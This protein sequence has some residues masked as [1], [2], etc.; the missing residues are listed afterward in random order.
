MAALREETIRKL[1]RDREIL[2]RRFSA[3]RGMDL[4]HL[5]PKNRRRVLQALRLRVEIDENGDAGISGMFDAD[6]TELLPMAQAPADEPYTVQFKHEIPPP[7]KG[8]VTL[9]NTPTAG[10]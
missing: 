8:V 2:L 7:Y 4:R 3:M 5:D 10:W 6:I 1:Q 9:D